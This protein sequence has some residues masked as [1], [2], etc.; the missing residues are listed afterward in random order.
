MMN[1][2]IVK[3]GG[4]EGLDL[5]RCLDDLIAI[6]QTRPLVVVHGVSGEMNRLCAER[7]HPVRML[8]S[9]SGHSSRYTDA[10]TRD[11]YVEAVESVNRHIVGYLREARID[12]TG[13]T[14]DH[15]AVCG[16]R[17]RAFRAMIDGRRVMVR[18][19]Y[20]GTITTVDGN[21]LRSLLDNGQVPVVPPMASSPDGLLNVDG[22]R[23]A[24][25]TAA[26]LNA[27][28]LVILSNVR[29]LYRNFPNEDSFVQTVIGRQI[30]DALNWAQGRMKRKVI[31]AGEAL[32]GGV[33]RVVIGDGRVD[34]PVQFALNGNGTEFTP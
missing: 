32:D 31:A 7:N 28:E 13:M 9:P 26:T 11:L 27:A 16:E 25:S 34:H 22:D 3:L 2:L 4:G 14:G 21:H 8:T 30:D 23:A 33:R 18:D 12:A 17:K 24:A 29:G 10:A 1:T 15:I 5:S 20:S 19:D 6:A